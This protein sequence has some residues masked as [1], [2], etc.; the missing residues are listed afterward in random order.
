MGGEVL[1]PPETYK[2]N[3]MRNATSDRYNRLRVEG[4]LGSRRFLPYLWAPVITAVAVAVRLPFENLLQGRALYPT[5]ILSVLATVLLGGLGPGILATVLGAVAAVYFTMPPLYTFIIPSAGDA[6][7][8]MFYLAV[9]AVIV[10]LAARQQR[11]AAAYRNRT[12]ELE[13]EVQRRITAE[14]AERVQRERLD[15]MLRSIGD[16][17]IATDASGRITMMNETAAVLT[18]WAVEAAVGKE[19]EEVFVIRNEQTGAA[20]ANPALRAIREGRIVGLANHTVLICKDGRRFSIDDSGA[21]I[22]DAEGLIFGAILVFRD[23]TEEKAREAE[24]IMRDRV[25]NL[26]HDAIIAADA[27]RQIK[28]WNRGAEEM[29]GWSESEA[30]GQVTHELLKTRNSGQI[31]DVDE[32]LRQSGRW[33]GQLV[34]TCKDGREITTESRHILLRDGS[35]AVA[36]I[37]E[38]NR[39]ITERLRVEEE[40]RQK[41][42]EAEEGR[43]ILEAVLDNIPE[44]ITIADAPG[45][46]IRKVSRY[47]AELAGGPVDTLVAL[48]AASQPSAWGLY[49]PD[50]ATPAT[51]G[52]LPLTRAVVAGETTTDEEWM[53]KRPDGTMLPILCNAAPIRDAAG[54]ITGGVIAWRDISQRRS[55]EQK[56]LEAAKLESIGLLAGGIAHDFNNL[57]TGIMGNASLLLEDIPQESPDYRKAE[58]IAKA[59]ERAAKLTQE[60]LAYSGRGRFFVEPVDLS[61]HIRELAALIEVAIPKNVDLTL[62]LQEGLAPVQADAAQLQQLV[63][64]IVVNAAEACGPVGGRVA[65][66]TRSQSVDHAYVQT[67]RLEHELTPGVFVVL[68]IEDNGCGMDQ[69]TLSKIFDPFFTTKF[70]GRGLGLAAVQGI[71]RGHKGAMKVYSAPGAG[72]KFLVLLPVSTAAAGPDEQP[73]PETLPRGAGTVLVIDDEEIVRTT[74]N[75][76]LEV[77]GYRVLVAPDG[78]A[79]VELFR[80]ASGEVSLVILDMTMPG[81][82][83]EETLRK[84]REVRP[85]VRVLLSSG[86]S[87]MEAV[88]RFGGLGLAGFLQKPYTVNTL[89]EKI[90]PPLPAPSCSGVS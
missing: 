9:S 59:A 22:V 45:V 79:G 5:F 50:G 68:E 56:M 3:G 12:V 15:V 44:G 1:G 26:S 64:N 13:S 77:L 42:A 73:V 53:L 34:H 32:V 36:R 74:A 63:M 48:P 18:G 6:A 61:N 33:D 76:A 72:T 65:I 71:V 88:G 17:V 25:V 20:V 54:R 37:L 31:R 11:A 89:A 81:I 69:P 4:I 60:M 27:S 23:V 19:I 66:R 39:D 10:I 58:N 86:F 47:G 80:A 70:T 30:L 62:D 51:A 67:L 49:R 16:G 24:L 87:E 57:L 28:S 85:D 75:A 40:L 84:L 90:Q 7:G 78:D 21:P 8:L 14:M 46:T 83:C 38:I 41:I 55:M 29:Y 2:H 52:E 35:G 82:T 43:R